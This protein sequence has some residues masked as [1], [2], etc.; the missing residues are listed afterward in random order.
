MSLDCETDGLTYTYGIS[1][2]RK[3]WGRLPDVIGMY[4]AQPAQVTNT[5]MI[6]SFFNRTPVRLNNILNIQL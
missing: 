2:N 6:R 3:W 5:V 4:T 1:L